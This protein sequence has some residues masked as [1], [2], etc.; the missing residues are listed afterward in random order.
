MNGT[1]IDNF[2]GDTGF[3]ANEDLDSQNELE[4]QQESGVSNQH[5]DNIIPIQPFIFLP[6]PIQ[7]FHG[8]NNP[9][10]QNVYNRTNFASSSTLVPRF[11]ME[12]R[13]RNRCLLALKR[14]GQ[15]RHGA[16]RNTAGRQYSKIG[17]ISSTGA[18]PM[19]N[20]DDDSKNMKSQM[21]RQR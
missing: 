16:N 2:A 7:H 9:L 5:N 4:G 14:L 20:E 11:R 15:A 6:A 10:L 17:R 19:G 8:N 21:M 3:E 12:L 1:P 18:K 13:N